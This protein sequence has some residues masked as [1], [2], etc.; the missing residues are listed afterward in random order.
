E[1]AL[2]DAGGVPDNGRFHGVSVDEALS[3]A[4]QALPAWLNETKK[5]LESLVSGELK[6]TEVEFLCVAGWPAVKNPFYEPA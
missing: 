1:V 2:A 4:N 6:S 3:K 5:L